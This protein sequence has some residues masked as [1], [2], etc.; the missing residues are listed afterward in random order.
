MSEEVHMTEFK[1]QSFLI[2]IKSTQNHTWQ[3][4][5]SGLKRT[6]PYRFE[7]HWSCCGCW[8]PLWVPIK[9]TNNPIRI[10]PKVEKLSVLF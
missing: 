4:R 8:I 7:A 2:K 9:K 1:G 3:E 5:C 6:K 10:E